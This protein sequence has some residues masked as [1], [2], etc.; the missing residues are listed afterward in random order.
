MDLERL[1]GT[2]LGTADAIEQLYLQFQK[3][4]SSVEPSWQQLFTSLDNQLDAAASPSKTEQAQTPAIVGTGDARVQELIDAYRT[5]GHLQAHI[6][7]LEAAPPEQPWQLRIETWGFSHDEL[8]KE[9]PTFGFLPEPKA[10]LNR[11]VEVLKTIYCGTVGVEFKDFCASE[12]EE[13][14]QHRIEPKGFSLD[15]TI[16]QKQMILE[17][18]NKSELFESF[19]H[20]KYPGQK[21]FSLEGAESLIPMLAC[22]IDKGAEVGVEEFIIG[23]AHRGRL[24]VLSNILN[25]SYAAIFTEFDEGYIQDSFE[26]TGDVKYHKGYYSDTLSSH[27]HKVSISVTP[28]PSHLEAVAPVVEGQVKAKQI[29]ADTDKIMP[30]LIHGD[31]S[32]SGQGVVYETLQLSDLEGYS[33][34]GTIHLIVNNQIGF[35]TLPRDARS[36]RYCTDIAKAFGSPVFHLNGEDP[37]GCFFAALLAVELRKKFKVD[38]FLDLVCYRKYGHN[39]SD[40]PAYTQPQVYQTI[41]QKRPTRELYR[42]SLIRQSLLGKEVAEKLEQEFK[43]S[44]QKALEEAKSPGKQTSKTNSIETSENGLIFKHI[45]TGVLP[46]VLKEVA[47]KLSEVPQGFNINPKIAALVKD[48]HNMINDAQGAKPIDW[49]MAELMAYGTLLSEG[50]DVRISGQDCCRGT[51]SHRHAMW[52]DQQ[53]SVPYFPLQ[54]ISANQGRF[55]IFNSPLSEYAVLGFEFGYSLS[56]K[57]SLVVWEAQFGDFSNGAQIM[58]DQFISTG[59]QKWGQKFSLTLLLPHGYEGQGPE[60]SSARIER[61]L[62]LAGQSNMIIA[63][64]TTPVQLF[65][66]LRRQMFSSVKKPLIVFTPKG[67]LRHP[68]CVSAFQDLTHGSFQEFLDDPQKP[69]NVDRVVCCSGRIYYDLV[70]TRAKEAVEGMAIIRV[71][72]LYPFDRERLA[73]LFGRYKRF[74][75]CVWIQEEPVNMGPC[76][77]ITPILEKMMPEGAKFRYIARPRSA[78]PAVGSHALHDA[79]HQA[80]LD[81]LFGRK[82]PSIFD[83]AGKKS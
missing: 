34:G 59:E 62:T 58:I 46:A 10:S 14:L 28:N 37:E 21:R 42:D 53:T 8:S 30:L 51:F 77:Y 3:D 2:G 70:A 18:L 1:I 5:F 60:H 26:G 76:T 50:Y 64:P 71:E 44:L 68:E 65:H 36:T 61:F 24:N 69:E 48:R 33:T 35:T 38:V 22:I 52:V 67:L 19:L 54:H 11:I 74:K 56:N 73:D 7:P 55:D 41:R 66:L 78:S 39:E 72:Q 20:M 15:L 81:A 31:A 16:E 9:F 32:I 13:W 79:E 23:M 4:P 49:G 6:N 45:N 80:L 57:N 17:Y 75:E 12:V 47:A 63:N 83:L 82:Q 27:G 29:H 25:K 40:E 43:Q